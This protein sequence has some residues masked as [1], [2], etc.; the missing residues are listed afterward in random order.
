M[1]EPFYVNYISAIVHGLLSVYILSNITHLT[2][3]FSLTFVYLYFLPTWDMATFDL[4]FCCLA[5]LQNPAL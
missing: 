5:T 3:S 2:N 1:E 4:L